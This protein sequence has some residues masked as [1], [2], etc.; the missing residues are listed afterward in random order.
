MFSSILSLSSRP[1]ARAV[2]GPQWRDRGNQLSPPQ[3]DVIHRSLFASCYL[4]PANYYPVRMKKRRGP[5]R[6][7]ALPLFRKL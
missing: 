5:Q 3:P 6:L 1:E 7:P 4:L 2:C